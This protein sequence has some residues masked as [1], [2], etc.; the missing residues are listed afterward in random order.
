MIYN[1]AF[2]PRPFQQDVI[3]SVLDGIATGRNVTVALGTPG[4][5]KTLAYQATA[6]RLMRE[7]L[8]DYI[9]VFVPRVSLAQQCETS[10]MHQDRETK[11]LRGYHKLFDPRGRLGKI[12]HI[13]SNPPLTQPGETGTG[14]VACYASLAVDQDSTFSDW[15][16]EYQGRFLLVADEAQFCGATDEKGNG[17][18]AGA[19]IADLSE[20]AAHTLLLTGTPYRADGRPLVLADYGDADDDGR[21]VLIRQVEA[22]Y[23]DGIDGGYLR[24]FEFLM[25]EGH[26]KETAVGREWSTEYKMS[27]RESNLSPVM[28]MPT[29]WEPLTDLV[30]QAVREKQ[31]LNPSYRGLISCMEKRDAEAVVNYLKRAHPSLRV[32]LA[33]SSDGA[34]AQKALQDFKVEQ[35]DVLVTVRMAFIGY[36]C[37]QITVVGILTHYRDMGHLMQLVGRGLRVWDQEPVDEQSCRVI[38]PDDPR[39]AAFLA[40]MREESDEG[41]RRRQERERRDDPDGPPRDDTGTEALTF[42]EA[43]KM[44]TVR[45]VSNDTEVEHDERMLI[46][47][48]KQKFGI[49]A[50]TTTL[51]ALVEDYGIRAKALAPS[52]DEATVH[53][54]EEPEPTATPLTDKQLIEKINGGV[55]ELVKAHLASREIFGGRAD[56]GMFVAKVTKRIN[57]AAGLTAPEVRT[58]EQAETRMAA[59][60]RICGDL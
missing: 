11:E 29:T 10:W 54:D 2:E 52:P 58:V 41:M 23:T 45:A 36:D 59:A 16:E 20:Y 17:T 48:L 35:A 60:R 39:M 46:E 34:A 49:S 31:I 56:Y 24:R 43:T 21:Q 40:K 28:R 12:R 47:L 13:E 26:I 1:D 14:F 15:A 6:T 44:T 32:F 37:P 57:K 7:G 9:A 8:I 51:A 18:K 22:T 42:I 5:G 38:A 27:S 53:F 4:T 50:D 33:V 19:L 30:V 3:E 55:P 25:H